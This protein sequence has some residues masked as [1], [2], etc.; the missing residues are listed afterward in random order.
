MIIKYE[1]IDELKEAIINYYEKE[2][3]EKTVTEALKVLT[4][5]LQLQ[6]ISNAEGVSLIDEILNHNQFYVFLNNAYSELNKYTLK[7]M[8]LYFKGLYFKQELNTYDTF[9]IINQEDVDLILTTINYFLCRIDITKKKF[10]VDE[11]FKY[12]NH[13]FFPV[14]YEHEEGLVLAIPSEYRL[15]VAIKMFDDV[16]AENSFGYKTLFSK[17]M[18]ILKE[19]EVKE[20]SKFVS[21]KFISS[22]TLEIFYIYLMVF[23]GA[24]FTNLNEDAKKHIEDVAFED[25]V[26]G[27]FDDEKKTAGDYGFLASIVPFNYLKQF[28]KKKWTNELI[29]KL[30][31][32]KPESDFAENFMF[33]NIAY[34][35]E[36]NTEESL[37]NYM[38]QKYQEKDP[39][40]VEYFNDFLYIDQGHPWYKIIKKEEEE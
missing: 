33:H 30:N 11:F 23:P 35:N 4:K 14:D 22:D 31:G 37:L 1:L 27:T 18:S 3:Y 10:V 36:H 2:E 28:D 20:I 15:E 17:L 6:F 29:R 16:N 25:F 13:P 32:N 7:G 9:E 8:L 26:K 19:D 38:D 40:I 12:I 24:Y 21:E 5:N 34:I 39:F